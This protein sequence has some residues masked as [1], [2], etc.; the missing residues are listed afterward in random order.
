MTPERWERIKQITA[1]ALEHEPAARTAFAAAACTGEPEILEEVLKLLSDA[2]SSSPS[3]LAVPVWDVHSINQENANSPHFSPN[4]VVAGRFAIERLVGVGGMGEVYAAVD[5]ELHE[6]VALK[7]IR[8]DIAAST[9][10]TGR[11]KEE[12][13]QTRRVTHPSVCRVYDLFSHEQSSGE[14]LWFLTMELLEGPTLSERLAESKRMSPAAALPLIRDMVAALSS[15]HQLGIVHRDFKPNNVML[16]KN[17][18]GVRERAVVT[19]F[20][21]ALSIDAHSADDRGGTPAYMSP[22]QFAGRNIGLPSDQFALGLVICEM[23][24]GSR[25][26]LDRSSEAESAKNLDDWLK[27]QGRFLSPDVQRTVTKCLKFRPEDRFADI[28]DVVEAL[29]GRQRR[30]RRRTVLVWAAAGAAAILSGVA[31]L[32]PGPDRVVDEVQVTPE[33]SLSGFPSLSRDGKWIAYTSDRA[34]SG[35][36]DV[37]VQPTAGGPPVRLTT[38]PA[39]EQ[40]P[41]ISPDGKLVAYRSER[42]GGGIYVIS[43]D[44]GNERLLVA[45]GRAPAFSP[46]GRT[47]A[48]WVGNT[49]DIGPSGAVFTIPA[50]G[51][52]PTRIAANFSVARDPVWHSNGEL[53]L[54]EG[55]AAPGGPFS[56]CAEWWAARPDGKILADTGA[57]KLLRAS[58]IQTHYPPVKVWWGEKLLFSGAHG[59]ANALWELALSPKRLAVSGPPRQA[60]SGEVQEW[61]PTLAED[62]QIAFGRAATSLH[63]WRLEARGPGLESAPVKITD[64]P[65]LDCCP[66]ISRDGTRLFFARRTGTFRDLFVKDLASGRESMLIRS[67]ED[68][69]WPVPD[70][71]GRR[72]AFEVRHNERPSIQLA[73]GTGSPQPLCGSCSHPTAWLGESAVF[74]ATSNGEIALA[75]VNGSGSKIAVKGRSGAALGD[76]DWSPATEYLL[77]TS[78]VNGASSR[79]FAA[80][81]SS[82]EPR[83]EGPWITFTSEGESADHPR[84]SGDGKTA[85]Y[86]SNRDGFTC[87][88]A[89]RFDVA[90]GTLSGEPFVITHYHNHRWG[91]ER[92]A[93]FVLG[94]AVA[95]QSVF[96]NLGEVTET[97]WRGRLVSSRFLFGR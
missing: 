75:Y 40:Q 24:A 85:F 36:L 18:A 31:L 62:G 41:S 91:P 72:V 35:N 47:I 43:R 21:M 74:Y 81:F 10:V 23:L 49:S 45:Q 3:F 57:L 77:F 97:V 89:Q 32:Y 26:D 11:F 90:S 94:L 56:T 84:W 1:D 42:L 50:A 80:R 82:Q 63:I 88:W 8:P 96:M 61:F 70:A 34:E 22:E 6:K 20:G 87:L 51:G 73:I 5:L 53:L 58:N 60:S 46:D 2:E 29:E 92:T 69:L 95:G 39:E 13:K 79:I 83:I 93:P 44:G 27:E 48:Y 54:F 76:S 55:C 14:P 86:L 4:Q 17:P 38:N 52:T 78:S 7:T 66:G 30:A 37:Y 16:V 9:W 71:T 25:P 65:E 59:T 19:D 15:A 12:V 33:T 67:P 68:K 64:D 28:R